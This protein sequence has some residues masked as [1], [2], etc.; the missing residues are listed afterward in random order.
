MPSIF[1]KKAEKLLAS[2]DIKIGGDRP[3]DIIVK[4]ERFYR[5]V[6]L[7][8]SL[9][10]GEAYLDG[11][12]DCKQL[13]VFFHK[14]LRANLDKQI[15]LWWKKFFFTLANIITNYQ[16]KTRAFVVG[17]K[18]YDIG[19]DLYKA[20]L[21]KHMTY[22]CGYW[23]PSTGSLDKTQDK[24]GQAA[25]TLEEAQEAK[26]DLI[27]RKLNL[28]K[29]QRILD[30]GSGWGSFA[31]Y[32][33]EKYGVSV[34]GITIS[35][36]QMALAQKLC[37]G[38]PVEFR[39]QDYRDVNEKFDHI[40]SIG[41]FEHVGYKNYR[42]YMQVVERCLKDGGLFLLHTIGGNKSVVATDPW[43]D[44]HIFPNGMLPSIKQISGAVE[45]LFVV[46]DWH[47]FGVDYDKTLMAWHANFNAHWPEF[48]DKYSERFYRMWNYYLLSCAGAFRARKNQLWQIVLSKNGVEGGYNIMR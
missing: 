38:L 44:K 46:E 20:M 15:G 28:Q 45:N 1:K 43:I 33:A 8:G 14:V 3:G 29:G 31:K 17:E 10:L 36:E 21:D 12:W 48:K 30:I 19:N 25:K 37:V 5:R 9:G 35:K 34:V 13:D 41:M 16:S 18:H 42:T 6:I 24:S 27:C 23:T 32:A 39:L 47:N 7:G 26:L 40:V 4:D 2:S 22:T 11:W